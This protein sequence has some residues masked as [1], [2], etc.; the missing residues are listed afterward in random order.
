MSYKCAC[1][2]ALQANDDVTIMFRADDDLRVV[3][4][5]YECDEFALLKRCDT[6]EEL[7][8]ARDSVTVRPAPRG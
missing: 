8:A 6:L 7:T 5:C 4:I 1:C 3:N 2:N